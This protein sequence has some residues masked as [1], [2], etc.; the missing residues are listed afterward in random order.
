MWLWSQCLIF[1]RNLVTDFVG[2]FNGT[3]LTLIPHD[4]ND[5]KSTLKL[6]MAWCR[7]ATSNSLNQCWQRPVTLYFITM[8]HRV[9]RQMELICIMMTCYLNAFHIS[10]PFWNGLVIRSCDVVIAVSID[11]ILNKASSCRWFE[12]TL[13]S[14]DVVLH[15][16]LNKDIDLSI[17]GITTI[18]T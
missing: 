9:K 12:T 3:V 2:I 13:H 18:G 11:K 16:S 14:C 15:I 17:I 10:G 5:D 7:Q 8:S 6:V 1:K 4:H